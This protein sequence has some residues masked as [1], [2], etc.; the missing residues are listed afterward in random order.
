MQVMHMQHY[1]CTALLLVP[2]TNRSL[3]AVACKKQSLSTLPHSAQARRCYGGRTRAQFFGL[4]P[5]S[6]ARTCC[7]GG[8][9]CAARLVVVCTPTSQ[10]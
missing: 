9:A 5:N 10:G 4:C 1:A 6:G 3:I 8:G 2:V 7:C